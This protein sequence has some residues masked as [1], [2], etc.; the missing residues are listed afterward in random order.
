MS[1]VPRVSVI[2][3]AFNGEAFVGEAL[4]SLRAQTVREFE[5]IVVDDGSTD[6]TAAIVA[7]FASADPR[8][9]MIRQANGGTQAARNAALAVAR[10]GWV[11]L[12]DQDDV[13]LPGK[14]EAQIALA[15]ADPRA[16]LLFTNYRTWDGT[17]TTGTR[18]T[19]PSK[20]PEGDVA[21]GLARGCLFQASTVMVPR[22]LALSF[23]GFDPEL[24]NA[25]DWDLWL[26]IAERGIYARGSLT[27]LV[28]YREWGGNESLN[29]MRTAEESVR[30]LEKAL[31]RPQGAR[32]RAACV[33]SLRRARAQVELARARSRLDDPTFVR[34]KL[35]AAFAA[36]RTPKHLLQWLA[37]AWPSTLGGRRTAAIVHA[38]LVRKFR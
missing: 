31:G 34:A 7:K 16:N 19:R 26:R 25:G 6:G 21:V 23:G 9:R 32:L 30:V 36:D 1:E 37:V 15:D 18:Y 27:P 2:V 12:L 20:F 29:H 22:A 33:R 8:F 24:R 35:H 4:A 11:G 3:A 28:L 17:S 38:K 14:L 5:A 13:W 10:G